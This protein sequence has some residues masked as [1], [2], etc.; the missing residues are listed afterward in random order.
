MTAASPNNLFARLKPYFAW[1]DADALRPDDLAPTHQSDFG[2]YFP[3]I[4][5]HLGCLGVIWAGWSP[6]AVGIAIALYWVRMFAI[7]AFYHR[8]FSHKT[9]KTS[10]FFQCVFAIIGMMSVQRGPLWWAS[11][12]RHHHQ[13]SDQEKDFHSPVRQG[14]WYAHIGWMTCPAHLATNYK[15]V[16]DLAKF[17]ELL[18]LNRFDWLVPLLMAVGLYALGEALNLYFPTLGT[19]GPQL[20]VWGFFIST[21]VLFH[22]TCTINSLAHIWGSQRF[23]SRDTSRNNFWL[24][25]ITMG[26]GWHNNHHR[27]PMSTRQGIYWWELDA[28]YYIL[29]MMSWLGIVWDLTPVPQSLYQEAEANRG[30]KLPAQTA[31]VRSVST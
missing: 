22:A 2:R 31:Q 21:V 16:P 6:V 27:Y 25:L 13:Y 12:H 28:S 23:E 1:L 7:T 24:S 20:I 8:Y 5:L 15:R 29:K 3:F 10:R 18:F 14:F 4:F 30:L 19:N 17:P 9:F 11:H 26:E